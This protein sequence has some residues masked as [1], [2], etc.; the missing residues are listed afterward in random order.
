[1]DQTMVRNL[2]VNALARFGE[3]TLDSVAFGV[4]GMILRA[5]GRDADLPTKREVQNALRALKRNGEVRCFRY[6]G[7]D[8]SANGKYLWQLTEGDLA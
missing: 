8:T 6:R 4:A 1:M 3:R 5:N 7:K 2:A